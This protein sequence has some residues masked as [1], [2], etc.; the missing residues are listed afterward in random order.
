MPALYGITTLQKYKKKHNRKLFSP[1][2]FSLC[3]ALSRSTTILLINAVTPNGV[4]MRN[5]IRKA[6]LP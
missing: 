6:P 1:I 5:E 4:Y 3:I 2:Y